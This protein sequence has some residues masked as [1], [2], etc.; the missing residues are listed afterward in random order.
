MEYPR[1]HVIL[2]IMHACL[3]HRS[4]V[5]RNQRRHCVWKCNPILDCKNCMPALNLTFDSVSIWERNYAN[6]I[7]QP[8]SPGPLRSRCSWCASHVHCCKAHSIARV[9]LCCYVSSP[10]QRSQ[11]ASDQ[12]HS[13]LCKFLCLLPFQI[14]EVVDILSLWR[15]V[16]ISR[17]KTKYRHSLSA[18]N[19][20]QISTAYLSN[21]G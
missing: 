4:H 6:G 9:M 17:P 8:F 5:T 15:S 7:H 2:L 14:L 13:V 18:I 1:I 12:Y 21:E 16:Y 20:A 11:P 19:T 10:L 3:I